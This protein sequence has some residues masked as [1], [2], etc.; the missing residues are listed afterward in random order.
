MAKENIKKLEKDNEILNITNDIL[1]NELYNI[2]HKV[3]IKTEVKD[4]VLTDIKKRV[5]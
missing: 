2:K 1:G 4:K 3:N 5:R